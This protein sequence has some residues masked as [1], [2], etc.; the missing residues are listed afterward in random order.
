MRSDGHVCVRRKAGKKFNDHCVI[1]I[2]IWGC[3]GVGFLRNVEGRLN[4]DADIDFLGNYM[5]PS[6]SIY[7][8]YLGWTG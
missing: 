4:G 8:H 7:C 2:M 5:I 6:V 3:I 1:R